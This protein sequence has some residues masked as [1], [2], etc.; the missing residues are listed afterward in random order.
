MKRDEAASLRTVGTGGTGD[1]LGLAGEGEGEEELEGEAGET[2]AQKVVRKESAN[3]TQVDNKVGVIGGDKTPVLA[4]TSSTTTPSPLSVES[5]AM[6]DMSKSDLT[7]KSSPPHTTPTQTTSS[8]PL[9][10]SSEVVPGRPGAE[11]KESGVGRGRD[12]MTVGSGETDFDAQ[13]FVDAASVVSEQ[14]GE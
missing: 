7:V 3:G 11:R 1:V 5:S 4:W 8:L 9:V 6:D 2:E 14:R 10:T 13:S 12:T